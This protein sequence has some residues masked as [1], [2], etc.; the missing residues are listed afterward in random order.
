MIIPLKASKAS[1]APRILNHHSSS[2]QIL[3]VVPVR[4]VPPRPEN[5]SRGRRRHRRLELPRRSSDPWRR[6]GRRRRAFVGE[7]LGAHR[8]AGHREGLR[9]PGSITF[10][11]R[12]KRSL[13]PAI[14]LLKNF[15]KM[16]LLCYMYVRNILFNGVSRLRIV[17]AEC[18]LI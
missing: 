13:L 8:P 1:F 15:F 7:E 12:I 14:K 3:V 10:E 18:Q 2:F 11:Q 16:T 5:Q 6:Q 9:I 17:V 4:L